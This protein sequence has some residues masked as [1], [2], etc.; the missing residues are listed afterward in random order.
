MK[1]KL[2]CPTSFDFL[3]SLSTEF[4]QFF[5]LSTIKKNLQSADPNYNLRVHA[6]DPRITKSN[7]FSGQNLSRT[8]N[9]LAFGPILVFAFAGFFLCWETVSRDAIAEF[10]DHNLSCNSGLF[11]G[12]VRYRIPVEPLMILMAVYGFYAVFE[13]SKL[14]WPERI[15]INASVIRQS[16]C[17]EGKILSNEFI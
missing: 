1:N 17:F 11:F 8:V 3:G 10:P 5:S 14:G 7:P 12:K 9:A 2:H 4:Y 6:V 15:R 16:L 13:L